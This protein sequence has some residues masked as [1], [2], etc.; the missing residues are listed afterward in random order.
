[1]K[2]M[3]EILE[4]LNLENGSNYKLGVLKKYQDN[5]TVKR[6]FKMALDK[7]SHTY[8]ISMKNINYTPQSGRPISLINAL[9]ILENEFC[10]RAVTG[11]KAIERLEYILSCVSESDAIIIEKIIGRDLKVNVG[12]TTANKVWKGLIVKPP[13]ERCDIG[14][15]KNVEKN[16]DFNQKVYSQCKMDGQYRSAICEPSNTVMMSRSGEEQ[17]FPLIESDIKTMEIDGYVLIG[18]L[19]IVLDEP[20]FEHL[21][22]LYKKSPETIKELEKILNSDNKVLPR[23]ISNGLINSLNV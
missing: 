8:N 14:T 22:E 4:E 23:S 13:Y 16:I 11:N 2:E 17:E 19:T 9:D 1:M 12:R 7:V 15:K 5:D 18:E 3:T 21:S 20:L 6:L 10:T